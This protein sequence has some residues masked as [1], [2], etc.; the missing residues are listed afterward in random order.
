MT[1]V[2]ECKHDKFHQTQ[3]SNKIVSFHIKSIIS[4]DDD[5]DDIKWKNVWK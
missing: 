5:T 2:S 4:T 3:I 1:I